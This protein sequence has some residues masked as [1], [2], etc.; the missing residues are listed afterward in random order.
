MTESR[1]S[2]GRHTFPSDHPGSRS[3]RATVVD[4]HGG[5]TGGEHGIGRF[6]AVVDWVSW[7]SSRRILDCRRDGSPRSSDFG[8]SEA[9]PGPG[10]TCRGRAESSPPTTPPRGYITKT[11]PPL[12]A[13]RPMTPVGELPTCR[14]RRDRLALTPTRCSYFWF[15][16]PTPATSASAK[17]RSTVTAVPHTRPDDPCSPR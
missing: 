3:L 8:H 12:R 10:Q 17:S 4:D 11:F 2:A 9:G 13:G 1:V 5:D 14:G 6:G 7:S 16:V 15:R